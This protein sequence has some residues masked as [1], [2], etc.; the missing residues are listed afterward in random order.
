MK[1]IS[2]L[3]KEYSLLA[4]GK[5]DAHP[6][7]FEQFEEW[8]QQALQSDV[9][10]PNAMTLATADKTGK[11]SARIVL[12]KDF[13]KRG[14]VFYTNYQS[15]KAQDLLENTQAS[16]VFLWL[17]LQR[18][19][20]IDGVVEKVSRTESVEYFNSRP[21]KSQLGAISSDQSRVVES[22][23]ILENKFNEAEKRF[24]G[25]DISCPEHWGGFRLI[26]QTI[27][28]WQGRQSRLHDR[29]R[30][31]NK[32]NIWTIDRLEP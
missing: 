28:F 15:H 27:E 16:L 30:Y 13:D 5:K 24:H 32:N 21:R 10:E 8:F 12:L 25:K 22:R 1:D 31:T 4:F 7:P 23:K 17:E 29:I 19:V 9:L 2:G 18:Q 20:R 6:D 26:P 3:R 14:F 11:P